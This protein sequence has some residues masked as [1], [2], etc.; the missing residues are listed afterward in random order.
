MDKETYWNPKVNDELKGIFIEKIENFGEYGSNLYKIQNGEYIV[1]VWG[2]KQLDSLMN[3]V[4]I[5]DE[6]ILR[7]VGTE[8]V[9]EHQMK[10]FELEI[11]NE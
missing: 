10:K 2:K 11:L 1:N 6:I 7:Y 3:L 5:G 4:T 8:K 9:N